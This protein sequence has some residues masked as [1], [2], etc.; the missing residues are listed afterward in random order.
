L[1]LTHIGEPIVAEMLKSVTD[2]GLLHTLRCQVTQASLADDIGTV[3]P[4]FITDE[5]RLEI[6]VGERVY[7]CDGAQTVDVLCAGA[8]RGVAMEAKLGDTLMAFDAFEKRFCGP[9]QISR[10]SDNRLKGT[11]ISLLE[12][13]LPFLDAR[14]VAT[15]GEHSWPLYGSWWLV[16]RAQVWK[17][18][19]N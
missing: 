4:A 3:K 1:E 18:W 12:R 6:K 19:K 16:V 8:E 2:R 14:L 7:S 10:H 11:I 13:R 9:C 15:V 5:A 17:R